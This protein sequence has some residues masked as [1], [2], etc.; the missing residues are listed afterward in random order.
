MIN[1]AQPAGEARNGAEA[2][3]IGWQWP[4]GMIGLSF[5]NFFLRIV[6]AG[7][8]SFW[9]TT[10][11]RKRIW[12]GVRINGEPLTYTGRG[13]ELLIGA[14]LIIPLMAL[15]VGLIVGLVML[16]GPKSTGAAIVIV[17]AYFLPISM[18][19]LAIYRSWRYRLARTRWRGIRMSLDGDQWSYAWTYFWTMLLIPLTAGW[20]MPWRTT[21]LQSLLTNST[22]F[23]NRKLTF[24]AKAGPLYGP[25]AGWYFGLSGIYVAM[26]IVPTLWIAPKAMRAQQEGQQYAGDASDVVV[27]ALSIAAAI[28]AYLLLSAWYRSQVLNHFAA[29]TRLEGVAAEG[30]KFSATTSAWGF[31]W[32]GLTN[33]LLTLLGVVV[34]GAAVYALVAPFLPWDQLANL[35]EMEKEQREQ[36][37]SL[38]M[39]PVVIAF[40]AGYLLFAPITQAR[41]MGYIVRNLGLEGSIDVAQI[42]QSQGADIKFGEGLAG[43]FD[44][45]AF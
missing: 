39:M 21:K 33:L 13:I 9:A 32:V 19:G 36:V 35:T 2:L 3:S 16:F 42:E 15:Y 26:F 23:G 30:A 10:E 6:T 12:S 29:H 20:I 4:S 25:F 5:A 43:A 24:D 1:D 34:I 7:I 45:D 8:Y 28:V 38:F 11:T 27:V 31:T 22:Y 37:I 18:I 40:G 44:V 41:S 17:L 14:L